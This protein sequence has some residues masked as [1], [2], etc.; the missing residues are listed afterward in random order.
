MIV[1]TTCLS[2]GLILTSMLAFRLG[3]KLNEKTEENESM[4]S[5]VL[6]RIA[7]EPLEERRRNEKII[8]AIASALPVGT[9]IRDTNNRIEFLDAKGLPMNKENQD[10]VIVSNNEK[11]VDGSMYSYSRVYS[12]VEDALLEG[13]VDSEV[14]NSLVVD[15]NDDD[16]AVAKPTKT[17]GGIRVRSRVQVW[18]VLAKQSER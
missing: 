14:L 17:T 18:N 4:K 13:E 15:F 3:V 11:E 12:V 5:Q 6:M 16:E 7:R 10:V 9:L 8:S 1:V 2:A